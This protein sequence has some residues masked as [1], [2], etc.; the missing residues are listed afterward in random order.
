[1]ELQFVTDWLLKDF[2]RVK[3]ANPRKI[4]QAQGRHVGKWQLAAEFSW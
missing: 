2:K 1:M 3:I 4:L